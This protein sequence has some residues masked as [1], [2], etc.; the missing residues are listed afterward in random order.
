[1]KIVEVEMSGGLGNQLFKWANGLRIAAAES[2]QLFLNL[3]F[4]KDFEKK[5]FTTPREFELFKLPAIAE[6]FQ[7]PSHMS[8]SRRIELLRTPM[9]QRYFSEDGEIKSLLGR[10]F[11]VKGNFENQMHI[12]PS[13]VV[14]NALEGYKSKTPW[15]NEKLEEFKEK[16][17]LAVHIRLGDYLRNANLYDVVSEDYYLSA[18]RDL[19]NLASFDQ[20][21]LFS[22]DPYSAKEKY[23][24]ISKDF[25]F[26]ES[27]K[28]TNPIE[29]LKILA[30]SKGI[31]STNSTFSWW[32]TYFHKQRE[33]TVIPE[34]YSN[35]V[36][37]KDASKLKLPNQMVLKN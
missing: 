33:L 8:F 10:V 35:I 28:D 26:L 11:I 25:E 24:K 2:A 12:P 18:I 1:L 9:K 4:Y 32:A 5:P 23:P 6:T 14:R 3:E 37:D 36:G 27:P 30:S 13:G 7:V 16:R 34:K 19:R 21:L 20:V 31:V 22:D 15:M 17:V 29:I